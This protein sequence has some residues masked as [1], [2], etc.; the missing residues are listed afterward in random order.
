MVSSP[1]WPWPRAPTT[2]ASASTSLEWAARAATG[3]APMTRR[4]SATCKCSR[5]DHSGPR[6]GSARSTTVDDHCSAAGDPFKHWWSLEHVE[7]VDAHRITTSEHD[8]PFQIV[9]AGNVINA[10]AI[11]RERHDLEVG[12]ITKRAQ[13]SHDHRHVTRASHQIVDLQV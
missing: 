1:N 13:L 9:A 3:C 7:P 12:P 6:A 5:R 2:I 8:A 10:L 4:S 11:D